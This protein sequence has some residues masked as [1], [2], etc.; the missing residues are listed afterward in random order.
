M[1][2]LSW[3]FAF[4]K[5]TL[6]E[7]LGLPPQKRKNNGSC[8][9]AFDANEDGANAQSELANPQPAVSLRCFCHSFTP[10]GDL[11]GLEIRGSPN[12]MGS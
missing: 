5:G 4:L 6:S 2:V 10:I 8:Q 9:P 3:A 12:H 7:G 1:G 11:G